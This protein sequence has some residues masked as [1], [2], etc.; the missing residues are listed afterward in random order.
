[1]ALPFSNPKKPYEQ[2][3]FQFSH[4]VIDQQG[5]ITHK[6]QYL[7]DLPGQFPNFDFVRK[8]KE[9]LEQDD[10]NIFRYANHENSVLCDIIQQ[11]RIFS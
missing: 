10:G 11:L 4:H 9:E 8:L 3:A 2:I 5:N 1:M 6:G 7:N